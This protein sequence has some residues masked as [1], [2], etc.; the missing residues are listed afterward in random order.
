MGVQQ[1]VTFS[2]RPVV[3]PDRQH[4]LSGHVLD[5][6]MATAGP[7]VL[8]QVGD[9]LGQPG[10]MGRQYGP[11]GGRVTQP[12]EDR[13]ALGRPQDHIK[14][15]HGI[16]AMRSAQQLPRSRVAA[17]EHGL[18]P[19]H[20]CFALQPK[21]AGAGAVPPAWGLAVAGQILLVVLGELAGVVL[22]PPH[23]K[24][25]DVRHHPATSSL[26]PLARANAPLVHCS[27]WMISGRA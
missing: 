3:E 18:E 6:A 13:D 8:V 14:A 21:A 25:G 27:P 23:R 12:I 5:T 7:Q 26:P 20:R 17:L 10:V 15:W 11:S 4:P 16:A 9:R 1:R 19:G 22:L 2:G 24:L